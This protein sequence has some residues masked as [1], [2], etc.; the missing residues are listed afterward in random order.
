MKQKS[1]G[2]NGLKP[3]SN[4]KTG[5]IAFN[6]LLLQMGKIELPPASDGE[7]LNCLLSRFFRDGGKESSTLVSGL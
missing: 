3:H 6:C 2:L 7:K 1:S 4:S 5:T